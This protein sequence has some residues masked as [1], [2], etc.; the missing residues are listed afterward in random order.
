MSD[1]ESPFHRGEKELQS[2]LGLRD[3]M[4]Q[5]GRRMI[6]DHISEQVQPFFSQLPLLLIG[7]A[8]EAGRPWASV[9]VGQPGF[10]QVVDPR[11]LRVTGRPIYGDPLNKA[12]TDGAD[13]GAL[14]LEF[15]TRRRNRVNGKIAHVDERDGP[16][17]LDSKPDLISEIFCPRI[18]VREGAEDDPKKTT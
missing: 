6:R 18:L 2:R 14:G 15:H 7:T 17:Q 9:L 16:H 13:I 12:L 5:L 8:D 10:L 3:Q 1:N 4:E 11:T